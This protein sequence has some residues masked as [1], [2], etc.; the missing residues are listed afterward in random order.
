[1]YRRATE[2]PPS[3]VFFFFFFFCLPRSGRTV[4]RVRRVLFALVPRFV[5]LLVLLTRPVCLFGSAR[6]GKKCFWI[7]VGS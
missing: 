3:V 7:W 4:A 6:R 5:P 2:P 1:M